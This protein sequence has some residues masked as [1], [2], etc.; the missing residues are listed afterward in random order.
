M[1]SGQLIQA[2]KSLVNKK[3]ICGCGRS[4]RALPSSPWPYFSLACAIEAEE[5]R[6]IKFSSPRQDLNMLQKE[7]EGT[8]EA[9]R[10]EKQKGKKRC[11]HHVKNL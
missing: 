9:E 2:L 5:P 1:E 3:C 8:Y 10:A 6:K 7:V 4:W 11:K